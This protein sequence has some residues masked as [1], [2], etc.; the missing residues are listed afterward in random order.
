MSRTKRPSIDRNRPVHAFRL[1]ADHLYDLP[2]DDDPVPTD[3]CFEDDARVVLEG[4]IRDHRWKLVAT[5]RHHLRGQGVDPEDV[6]Q[7]VC[8]DAVDGQLTLPASASGMLDELR[9]EI[10]RRCRSEGRSS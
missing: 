5:A 8:A 7:D 4:V 3:R 10:A 9:C 1:G 6:V 2:F